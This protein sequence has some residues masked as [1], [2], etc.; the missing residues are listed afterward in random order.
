MSNKVKMK[1]HRAS[2]KRFKITGS[3][4]I[5]RNHSGTGHNTG[6]KSE[7]NRLKPETGG[8]SMAGTKESQEKPG[9]ARLRGGI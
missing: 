7:S 8:L 9:I 6:K 1:T 5:M 3:G 4:K 2:A